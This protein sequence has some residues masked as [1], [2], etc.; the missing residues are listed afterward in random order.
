MAG[1]Q[2]KVLCDHHVHALLAYASR[3]RYPVRNRATERC[4]W[5]TNVYLLSS[6]HLRKNCQFSAP[7]CRSPPAS[8]ESTAVEAVNR[9]AR[10]L[11]R[12]ASRSTMAK[13]SSIVQGPMIVVLARSNP[14]AAQRRRSAKSRAA[15]TRRLVALPGR[16][17]RLK[18]SSNHAATGSALRCCLHI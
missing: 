7:R 15:S 6:V 4:N 5:L 12:R 1:K 17:P 14:N 11:Q 3:S 8:A 18:R 13:R 10:P 9:R 16:W 2:A